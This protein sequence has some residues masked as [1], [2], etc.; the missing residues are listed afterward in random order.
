[1]VGLLGYGGTLNGEKRMLDGYALCCCLIPSIWTAVCLKAD[2]LVLVVA[3]WICVSVAKTEKQPGIEDSEPRQNAPNL[4][5]TSAAKINYFRPLG[6]QSSKLR[7]QPKITIHQSLKISQLQS[8][9]C[10]PAAIP[11]CPTSKEKLPIVARFR[12]RTRSTRSTRTLEEPRPA[13]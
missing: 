2:G 1:M 9:P 5:S 7:Q 13:L 3:E 6:S 10:R 8:S 4:C 11:M 12:R